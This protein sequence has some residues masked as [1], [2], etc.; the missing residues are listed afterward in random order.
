MARV[1]LVDDEPLYTRLLGKEVRRAGHELE[2]AHGGAEAIAAGRRFR[3]DILIVDW[4]LHDSHRGID[5]IEALRPSLPALRTIVIT[6]YPSLELADRRESANIVA[7]LEKPVGFEEVRAA[8]A[9]CTAHAAMQP[10]PD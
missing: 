8:L 3:P 4:M 9:G 1:L 2:I 6:G 7:V 5:V 10:P